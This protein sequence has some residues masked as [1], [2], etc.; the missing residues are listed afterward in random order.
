MNKQC[1]TFKPLF[2]FVISIVSCVVF[3]KVSLAYTLSNAPQKKIV[4]FQDQRLSVRINPK[5]CSDNIHG[6]VNEA[7]QFM[8]TLP[9]RRFHLEFT[10]NSVWPSHSLRTFQFEGAILITCSKE[11]KEDSN[12]FNPNRVAGVAANNFPQQP[13][14]KGFVILNFSP[15]IQDATNA[16]FNNPKYSSLKKVIVIAHE[17][18]HVLG[19][20]HSSIHQSL[21]NPFVWEKKNLT[22]HEDDIKGFHSIYPPL[23]LASHTTKSKYTP[24]SSIAFPSLSTEVEQS[25]FP[26]PLILLFL[27]CPPGIKIY[28]FLRKFSGR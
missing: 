18:G 6:L 2:S 9:K 14:S 4:G 8:N 22:F 20:G 16:S 13:L 28:Y 10:K 11:F 27:M 19:L 21:M 5:N 12:G 7:I 24:L 23:R 3:S 1:F 26:W 15:F 17:L 25:E